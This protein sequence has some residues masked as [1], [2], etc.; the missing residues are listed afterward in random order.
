MSEYLENPPK[1]ERDAEAINKMING[2]LFIVMTRQKCVALAAKIPTG[3]FDKLKIALSEIG[4]LS[5]SL[6]RVNNIMSKCQPEY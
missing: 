1:N 2:W 3:E 4:A 5:E 6:E